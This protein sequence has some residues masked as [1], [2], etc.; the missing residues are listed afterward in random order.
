MKR[1]NVI[2]IFM[3]LNRY[4]GIL[5]DFMEYY[6]ILRESKDFQNCNGF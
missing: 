2:E 5:R 6:G 1:F 4:K 3:D